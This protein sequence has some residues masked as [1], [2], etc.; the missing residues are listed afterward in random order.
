MCLCPYVRA[1]TH[2]RALQPIGWLPPPRVYRCVRVYMR[3]CV[4]V[5]IH[6][7]VREHCVAC[8]GVWILCVSA[9][10]RVYICTRRCMSELDC[11]Y[12]GNG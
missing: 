3:V 7:I 1:S 8:L 9:Y 5:C 11:H 10:V 12:Q 4:F 6:M 2:R